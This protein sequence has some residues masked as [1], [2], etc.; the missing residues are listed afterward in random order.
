MPKTVV[1]INVALAEIKML[2]WEL[3]EDNNG[4]RQLVDD[5]DIDPN[6]D[7]LEREYVVDA[8]TVTLLV[9]GYRQNVIWTLVEG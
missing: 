8:D 6:T 1:G 7:D 5:V 9:D 3:I 2:G 4:E